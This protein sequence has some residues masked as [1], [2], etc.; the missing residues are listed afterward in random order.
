MLDSVKA[1]LT[2][3]ATSSLEDALGVIS[4]FVLLFAVLFMPGLA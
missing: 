3:E 1:L 2:R 4:L